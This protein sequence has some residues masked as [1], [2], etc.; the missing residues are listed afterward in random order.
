MLAHF[1]SFC[2]ALSQNSRPHPISGRLHA[3]H[4]NV[5]S[6]LHSRPATEDVGGPRGDPVTTLRDQRS[7]AAG[8]GDEEEA[9]V[10][11]HPLA[12]GLLVLAPF[13]L[14]GLVVLLVRLLGG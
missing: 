14:G 9:E 1:R 2:K 12:K 5:P 13:V 10:D 11:A 7:G 6:R 4:A 8:D 3:R